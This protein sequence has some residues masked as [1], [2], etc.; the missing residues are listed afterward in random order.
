MIEGR[1]EWMGVVDSGIQD[2]WG[3]FFGIQD[4]SV[5]WVWEDEKTKGC[6]R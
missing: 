5:W 2:I 4:E 3:E 6:G 1:G